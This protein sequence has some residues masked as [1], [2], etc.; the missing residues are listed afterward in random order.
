MFFISD[1]KC[2]GEY[3]DKI[4][5]FNIGSE[6]NKVLILLVNKY[7]KNWYLCMWK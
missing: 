3:F 1:V 4:E 5:N 6:L 2:E 7:V